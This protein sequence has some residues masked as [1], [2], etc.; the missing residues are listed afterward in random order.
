MGGAGRDGPPVTT[1]ALVLA[2]GEGRRMGEPKQLVDW[3][4]RPMLE[5]VLGEVANWPSIDRTVVVLGS[6]AQAIL[7]E[8]DLGDVTIVIN[9]EW[10][11]GLASSLRVGL[12]ALTHDAQVERVVVVLGDQPRIPAGVVARLL[13]AQRS[14]GL[15]VVVPKYRYTWGNPVLI[16]RSLWPRIMTSLEGDAG[17]RKLFQAHREWVEEVWFEDLPPRDIDTPADLEE[18]RPRARPGS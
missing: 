4:G 11:E 13:A 3:G 14:S 7:E 10:E 2:A 8:V 18:L 6:H 9:P 5:H 1:A 16:D 15:P 17:A 12:D